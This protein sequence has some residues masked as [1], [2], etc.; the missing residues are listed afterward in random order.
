MTPGGDEDRIVLIEWLNAAAGTKSYERVNELIYNIRSA[1]TAVDVAIRGSV[2]FHV[3]FP[4]E[5]IPPEKER[6]RREYYKVLRLVEK[7]FKEYVFHP[8][9]SCI[10]SDKRRWW[11]DLVGEP[12]AGD[13][14]L[15]RASGRHVNEADAVFGVFRL[16]SWGYLDRV[17]QCL[18]C[19]KW[20][21]AQPSHKKF[22][23]TNC[24]LKSFALTPM[25][26]EKRAAYMRDYRIKEKQRMERSHHLARGKF[27]NRKDLRLAGKR[28]G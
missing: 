11:F 14:K 22:C 9:L 12:V 16:A 19:K 25:Q 10:R 13:Y 4:G 5:G 2:F 7:T 3:G 8:R 26:K 27:D 17:R 23:T 1:D 15:R 28:V 20:L 18:T 21:Y 6:R 24:Q